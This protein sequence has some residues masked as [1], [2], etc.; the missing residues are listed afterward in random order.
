MEAVAIFLTPSWVAGIHRARPGLYNVINA[1]SAASWALAIGVG[2]YYAGPP[3]VEVV[4]DM[5]TIGLVLAIAIVA[6]GVVTALIRRHR[7]VTRTADRE[8]T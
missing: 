4:N 2:G 3:V 6:V 1:L 8:S 7:G 5:G